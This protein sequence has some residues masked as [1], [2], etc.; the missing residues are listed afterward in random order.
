MKILSIILLLAVT[1]LF[2]QNTN[3]FP[4]WAKGVVWYQI[5]PERFRNGDTYNDPDATKTFSG[6]HHIVNND[7]QITPWGSDWYATKGWEND[8]GHFNTVLS[9]RRYGGDLAGVIEK[10]PY[11]KE[12]G[13]TG[14]YFNPLFEANSLH[15]YDGSSFHHIDVNF[16]SNPKRD[17]ELIA[18]ED[19]T[20]PK[21]WVITSADSLFFQLLHKAKA[22]GIRVI[23]D[24]VFNHTGTDFFAFKDIVTYGEKSRYKNW[25]MINSFDDP[26][27]SKNEFVY[28]GWWDI[29]DLPQLNRDEKT[30]HPE[31]REYIFNASRK[32]LD[33]NNDGNP[34]DGIDGWRLDVAR[35]VPIGFWKEWSAVVKSLNPQAL[36]IGE[37]WEL[38]PDFVSESGPFDALMNYTFAI[39]VSDYFIDKTTKISKREFINRLREIDTVYPKRNLDLLQNLMTSHDTERLSSMIKNPDRN[40]DRDADQRNSNYSPAK[41]TEQEYKIQKLILAFQTAYRGA[42]MVYYGDEVGMW[43][44]DD[45]HCRKPMIWNDINYD[46]EVITNDTPFKTG[47][48]DYTVSVNTDLLNYYK[49]LLALR[50]RYPAL[51]EGAL[52][53]VETGSENVVAFTRESNGTTLLCVFNSIGEQYSLNSLIQ[54]EMN[55]VVTGERITPQSVLPG[56]QAIIVKK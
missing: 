17:R 46:N 21:T 6:S 38:S 7:W 49:Q 36:I 37:L 13:I 26:N 52:N 8:Y 9:L 45:P 14:I 10:L 23:I 19:P 5:F 42:P 32:W 47:F 40:Y 41:P 20:N 18:T 3:P 1:S 53:F 25:F 30:L 50:S 54:T 2:S 55:C 11:I 27:T 48:G 12:L 51:R 31:V 34:E 15:K 24:G 35:D 56:Y 4:D 29:S 22:M 43:G 44:A 39:A 33:P 16:G 28:K